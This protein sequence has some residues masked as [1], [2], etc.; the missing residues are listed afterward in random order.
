M[1]KYWSFFRIRF[2]NSLQYRSA[3]YA[4]IATQFFWGIMLILM[5]RAFY[6]AN[7]AAFPMTFQQTSTYVWL[8]QAFLSL[9][10]TYGF[11]NELFDLITSGN[12]AYELVRPMDL[13][14]MWITKQ[15]A[16]RMAKAALRCFPVL[17][18]AA[19]LPAP[20]GLT[21]PQDLISFFMFLVTL[22][23]GCA[24]MLAFY[25]LVYI[26]VFYTL[27]PMG[28]RMMTAT[29]TDFL[30]GSLIPIPFMGE[31]L[32]RF[33]RLTPFAAM[34]NLP[35]RIYSGNIAGAEMVSGFILQLFWLTALVLV[36]QLW[37]G[38]T[39]KRVVVQGG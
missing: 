24:T 21:A 19:L 38:R 5:Y 16:T 33:I 6:Q 11:D 17:I 18:F 13:Y 26:S 29:I 10:M 7:P 12:V 14:S 32:Q 35:L 23:L 15:M 37:M 27:S 8:Q 39:L 20:Y 4:G 2:I 31:K 30:T 28:V 3:A 34:Q 36:G 25:M 1:K 22:F 9:F